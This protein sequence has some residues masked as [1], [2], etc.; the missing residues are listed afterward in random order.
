VFDPEGESEHHELGRDRHAG[1]V[2]CDAGRSTV[3]S[4][5]RPWENGYS[6]SFHSRVRD[7]FLALEIF[8]NLRAGRELTAGWKEYYNHHRPHRSLGY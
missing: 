3:T 5:R 7:E 2:V 4:Q 1:G 8:Y 6:E